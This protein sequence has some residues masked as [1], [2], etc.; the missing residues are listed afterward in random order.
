MKIWIDFINSPQVS[1]FEP[2]IEELT[3]RG[4]EFVLTCRDSA[5]TVKLVRQKGWAHQIVGDRVDKSLWKKL[6]AFPSRIHKL[7][8]Y[9]KGRS[10]DVA[11]C[12]SSFYL[13]LTARLLGIPSIYTND[14]EHAIGNIP[15]FLFADKIFIPENLSIEK[16]KRQGARMS[17][18]FQY[19]GIKEGVYLWV[20]GSKIIAERSKHEGDQKVIFIR[21]E[22]QTAQYYSGKLN[23]LDDL[24]LELQKEYKVTILA[25]DRSQLEHYTQ[26]K[27][28]GIYVPI[29]PIPFDEV[30]INCRLFIGAGGSMTREM[31][32]IGIPTISVYQG[33]LLDVDK[34][35]IQN[36]Y[37]VHQPD[38]SL[39]FI[40]NILN[41]SKEAG[42]NSAL[43]IEKGKEAYELFKSELLNLKK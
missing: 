20:K 11:I 9:L 38:L 31:S 19:P 2:L 22:P 10:V 12:Q 32:M 37:M 39:D 41:Q 18:T 6:V 1:F 30:A 3:S 13:P 5:N 29:D 33:E 40:Y 25:R 28:E 21:P 36:G 15:S 43:L 23:F 34:F 16:I 24:L 7:R 14:N 27:F 26:P 8:S 17:R 35:L 4:H 42:A